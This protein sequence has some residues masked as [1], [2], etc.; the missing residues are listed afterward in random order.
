MIFG[1]ACIRL[2]GQN[3]EMHSAPSFFSSRTML[4]ELSRLR[5]AHLMLWKELIAAMTSPLIINQ[6][7]LK[8]MH[9]KPSGL[10]LCLMAFVRWLV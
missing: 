2:I 9:V 8:K 7:C 1:I 10:G 4:A 3:F 6:H 5:S